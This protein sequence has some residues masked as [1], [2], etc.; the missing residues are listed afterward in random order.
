M[1][2][3]HTE[4]SDFERLPR[5]PKASIVVL[6][7]NHEQFLKEAIESLVTQLTSFSYEIVIAED[8]SPD[9][10]RAAA[11]ELQQRHPHLVRVLFSERNRGMNGNFRFAMSFCRGEYIAGCEGDD[12]WIDDNKLERQV[13]ALERHPDTDMAFT[14][15]YSLFPD[16]TR[17]LGCDYGPERRIIYPEEL[18]AGIGWIAPTA[19]VITRARI[20]R[21]LPTW[22]DDAPVGDV[23]YFLAAS[24]RGGAYY[25][26]VST[27]CY[28]MAQPTSFTVAHGSRTPAQ[29]LE[30]FGAMVNL[31]ERACDHYGVPK[32]YLSARLNDFRFQLVKAHW[33][34]GNRL[35]ALRQVSELNPRFL[36]AGAMRRLS[37]RS[38]D[39][40]KSVELSNRRVRPPVR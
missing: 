18:F 33:S 16:G 29:R 28:R 24:A 30:Y 35:A 11:I 7:Y 38:L 9:N 5:D 2:N 12:F 6:A 40:T 23:F 39:R 20:A 32:R 26:P 10:T 36:L 4:I 22:L 25:E 3:H 8:A 21:G 17:L 34:E 37:R 27:I 31:I 1:N 13:S 19:S 14:R 15:G